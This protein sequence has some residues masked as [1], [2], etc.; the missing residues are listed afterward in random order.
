MDVS[1]VMYCHAVLSCAHVNLQAQAR[2]GQPLDELPE[3]ERSVESDRP[4]EVR[5]QHPAPE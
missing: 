2:A 1:S 3:R 5:A 4:S